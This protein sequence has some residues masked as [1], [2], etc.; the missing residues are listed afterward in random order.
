METGVRHSDIRNHAKPQLAISWV[1]LID[2]VTKF[3]LRYPPEFM[4]L[5][6]AQKSVSIREL[7]SPYIYI[8][9]WKP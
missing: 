2:N 6:K 5:F 4:S 9:G 1:A 7:H 8:I 3:I